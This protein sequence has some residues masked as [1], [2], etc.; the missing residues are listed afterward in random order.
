MRI[1]FFGDSIAQ[2]FFDEKGGWVQRLINKYHML[3]YEERDKEN[4]RYIE[5]FNL[6]ISG[7]T[8]EGVLNRFEQEFSARQIYPEENIVVIAIGT[9]DAIMRDNRAVMD[10]Y[11]FQEIL[12]KLIDTVKQQV[13]KILLVGLPSVDESMTNP[14]PY[15]STK[16][17]WSNNILNTFED[18][19]KQSAERKNIAFVPIHD[20]FL[21]QMEAGQALLGDG[22]HP[23]RR[24][25]V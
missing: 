25:H 24:A 1:L 8:V 2:G 9:N 7:D 17:Q 5:C 14:W 21:A 10:V 22:L 20:S 11:E 16:K 15:S 19:I 3:S 18:T 13:D 23:D 12:E 6:G 4:A